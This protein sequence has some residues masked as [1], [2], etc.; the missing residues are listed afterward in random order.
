MSEKDNACKHPEILQGKPGDCSPKQV[1]ECHG[2]QKDINCSCQ[3]EV[4]VTK[5]S[6]QKEDN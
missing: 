6:C 3:Q 5:C 4:E 1:E 2:K